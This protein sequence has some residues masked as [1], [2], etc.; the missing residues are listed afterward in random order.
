MMNGWG[1]DGGMSWGTGGGIVLLLLIAGLIV[2]GIFFVRWIIRNSGNNGLSES[3][4]SALEILKTRYTNGGISREEYLEMKSVLE[5][6]IN[7]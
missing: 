3:K 1:Y 6:K 5:D 2:S 4:S 7:L